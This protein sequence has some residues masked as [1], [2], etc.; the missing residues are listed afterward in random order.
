MGGYKVQAKHE[1][2]IEQLV[3]DALAVD[4]AGVFAIVLECVPREVA[5]LVTAEVSAATIGI[6][7]G[8]DCDGQ[9]LVLHDIL[10]LSFKLPAKF[11]HQYG[12]ASA[13]IGDTARRFKEDVESRTYPSDEQSYHVPANVRASLS[14]IALRSKGPARRD[15]G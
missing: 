13:T 12:D 9:V 5:E 1:R 3:Q 6:G 10:R 2:D 7:A 8:P 14:E 11:V 15:R 4:Q